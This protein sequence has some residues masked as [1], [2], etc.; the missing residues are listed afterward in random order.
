MRE[1][2]FPPQR[3]RRQSSAAGSPQPI[4][5]AFTTCSSGVPAIAAADA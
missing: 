5:C 1:A 2:L 3:L 4:H